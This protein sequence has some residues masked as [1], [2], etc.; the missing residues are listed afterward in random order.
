MAA[1]RVGA[2]RDGHRRLRRSRQHARTSASCRRRKETADAGRTRAQR[3]LR[4]R[5]SSRARRPG[6]VRLGGQHAAELRRAEHRDRRQSR[7]P[8]SQDC[9]TH[10]RAAAVRRRRSHNG[11]RHGRY[12]FRADASGPTTT[13]AP[14]AV[15]GNDS[16]PP[17]AIPVK[18]D[19]GPQVRVPRMPGHSGDHPFGDGN[20]RFPHGAGDGHRGDW[21]RGEGD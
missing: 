16:M 11:H 14:A 7:S 3:C 5:R 9:D 6:A 20:H 17:I 2:G 18:H 15:V 13:A 1:G 12:P 10:R 19:P 21:N 4:P 8:S